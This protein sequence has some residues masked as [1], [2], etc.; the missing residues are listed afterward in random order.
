MFKNVEYT[1]KND[2]NKL[3]L[4]S[5]SLFNAYVL[6]SYNLKFIMS[7]YYTDKLLTKID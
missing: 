4:F 2:L 7:W 6:K 3:I 5:F 1:E